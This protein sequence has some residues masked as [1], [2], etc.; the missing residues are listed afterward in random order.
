MAPQRVFVGGN[1]KMNGDKQSLGQPISTLDS[2]I[3][4]E[5]VCAAP[6]I[7]LD[8]VRSSL[9]PRISV[10]A[11]NCFRGPRERLQGRSG[12]PQE[13][14][15]HFKHHIHTHL[16]SAVWCFVP[17]NVKDWSNVVLAYEPVWAIVTSQT[18]T[19]E[20][21]Q[22]VHQKLRSWLRANLSDEVADSVRIIYGGQPQIFIFIYLLFILILISCVLVTFYS[23]WSRSLPEKHYMCHCYGSTLLS[24]QG[25]N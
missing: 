4:H 18:A 17:E 25:L 14:G 8:F 12:V 11:Q 3:L 21:A 13:E 23:V 22:E 24:V 5:V 20:Q 15:L 16:F 10:A 1:R 2:A 6:S 19:P 9:D 7:Y